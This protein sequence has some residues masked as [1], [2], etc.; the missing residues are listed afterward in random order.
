MP[1]PALLCEQDRLMC[2]ALPMSWAPSIPSPE[3]APTR[4]TEADTAP[5]CAPD[6][7]PLSSGS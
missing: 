3:P 6:D 7:P 4:A 5:L 2:E 1:E